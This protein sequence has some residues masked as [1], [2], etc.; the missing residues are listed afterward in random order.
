MIKAWYDDLLHFLINL[1]NNFTVLVSLFQE[2]I[3]F[4]GSFV[5]DPTPYT[6]VCS[7]QGCLTRSPQ[8]SCI[9]G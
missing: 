5:A 2:E 6:A 9:L 8:A 4:L 1:E 3:K 7:A